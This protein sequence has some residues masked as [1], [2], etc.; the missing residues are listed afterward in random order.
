MCAVRYWIG[1]PWE[2]RDS[3]H[4]SQPGG[5]SVREHWL[6]QL[7]GVL[8]LASSEWRPGRLQNVLQCTGQPLTPSNHL[9]PN[10]KSDRLRNPGLEEGKLQVWGVEE[11]TGVGFGRGFEYGGQLGRD[12]IKG[13]LGGT[14]IR[15]WSWKLSVLQGG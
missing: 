3:E 6:S 12:A 7:G 5:D 2:W 8:L 1:A 4:V 11:M 9:A 13:A 15:G 14:F 10:V